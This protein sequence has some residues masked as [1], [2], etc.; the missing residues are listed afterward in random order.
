MPHD[1]TV[2]TPTADGGA[3]VVIGGQP[4]TLEIESNA[5]SES[6][7]AV[8]ISKVRRHKYT[9]I[10]DEK[11]KLNGEELLKEMGETVVQEYK[12]DM[13]SRSE[14]ET[15]TSAI[16][17][18]FTSFHQVKNHPWPNAS[19]VNLPI[20]SIAVLQ[21]Q[22]R[23]YDAII[24]TK[25]VARVFD[26]GDN[27]AERAK[28]V[29]QYMNYELLYKMPG[30]ESQFDK[31]LMQLPLEGSVF[32]KT[33]RDHVNKRNV[34]EY[35]SAMDLVMNYGAKSLDDAHR[36]THKIPL[37]RNDIRKRVNA[38]VFVQEAWDLKR[39]KGIDKTEIK[40][41]SDKAEGAHETVEEYNAPRAILEQHRN[42]DITG[43]GVDGIEEPYIITVDLET[44]KVLRIIGR[45]YTDTQGNAQVEEYFTEYT[46]FPNPE[47]SYGLGFGT[48]LRG[49]NE[50]SNAILNQIID[51]GGLA[52]MQGGFYNKQSGLKAG[53]LS[54]ERGVYKAVDLWTDDIRK[55]IFS[56]DFKGPNQTLFAVLGLLNEY[57]QMVS[58][59][60]ETSTGT[61]PPSDTPATT[62]LALIEEGRKIFTG[63]HK[64]VHRS[65][66]SELKKIYRLDSRYLDEEEYFR[67]LGPNNIPEGDV[68]GIGRSDF[69]DTY[70]IVPVSDPSIS[71][72]AE[73]IA[74]AQQVVEDI[75]TNPLT[76]S[77][78]QANYEA[79]RRWYE[80]LEV[81]N[82]DELLQSPEP[83]D[84]SPFEEN[85]GFITLTPA[86]VLPQ[87]N[88]EWHLEVLR[89]FTE[90]EFAEDLPPEGKQLTEQHQREHTAELYLQQEEAMQEQ[91]QAGLEGGEPGF[92]AEF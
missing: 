75:R 58:G 53:D 59:I 27:D 44:S 21:F 66:K 90:G 56:F 39:G 71:S 87:Q 65:F 57:A 43:D 77:N 35:I 47:G 25:E 92:E 30:F 18:L 68:V 11:K 14:W 24:P 33:Y 32:K 23:A 2:T 8:E 20:L 15:N 54:F 61:M 22:A 63:I 6:N 5:A 40:E 89:I 84:M 74:K 72:R 10:T 69:L 67:V 36:V 38:G 16:L 1:D 86:T 34:S 19:N 49:L 42:W 26:P 83:Q 13:A 41:T 7:L 91:E 12:A 85:A 73:K 79:T 88:H 52:T 60:S 28:R 80:T 64:R 9:S 46:F 17:K 51:A 62:V 76:A 81:A 70:D 29:D 4:E 37:T 3:E 50:S 48:L 82:I 78:Q 55:A 31:T 45:S